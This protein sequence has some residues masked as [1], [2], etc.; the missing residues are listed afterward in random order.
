M[1][2]WTRLPLHPREISFDLHD[3][4]WTPPAIEQLGEVLCKFPDVFST[5]KTDFG[6]CSLLTFEI[7]V[8]EGSALVLSLI[9]I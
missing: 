7:S 4:G 6:C 3:P 2:V 5:L 9:H 8:P 1:R